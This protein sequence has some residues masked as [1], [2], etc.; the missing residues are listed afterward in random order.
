MFRCPPHFAAAD[1][2]QASA[3]AAAAA[4]AVSKASNPVAEPMSVAP[5]TTCASSGANKAASAPAQTVTRT[6]EVK[7]VS[8]DCKP[9]NIE[10]EAESFHTP[11]GSPQRAAPQVSE[12]ASSSTNA[13][14]Q[15]P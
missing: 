4:L 5:T 14:A 10:P 1:P 7:R 3:F 12:G 6:T 15:L 8:F 2:S 13:A 11:D 9:D